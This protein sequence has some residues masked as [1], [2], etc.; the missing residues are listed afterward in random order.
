MLRLA[1]AA[2]VGVAAL[3]PRAHAQPRYATFTSATGNGVQGLVTFDDA[4]SGGLTVSVD[5]CYVN[6]TANTTGHNWHVHEHGGGGRY[7]L[8][9]VD[10][11]YDCSSAGGHWDPA[12]LETPQF[13]G[14][15]P[16][17]P[18]RCVTTGDP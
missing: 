1:A 3:A 17:P 12:Y 9:A 13:A 10:G 4:T 2:V 15:P 18:Y 7:P 6:G 16:P 14:A 8:V 11:V 5:L